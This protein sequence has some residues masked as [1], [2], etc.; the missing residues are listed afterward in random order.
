M[1][2]VEAQ[3]GDAEVGIGGPEE[4]CSGGEGEGEG[5]EKHR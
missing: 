3:A 5:E 2:A 1:D 4:E